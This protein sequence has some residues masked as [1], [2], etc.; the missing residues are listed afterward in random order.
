[1][2]AS[3]SEG[4]TTCIRETITLEERL[5]WYDPRDGEV[6]SFPA[7][8]TVFVGRG[9]VVNDTPRHGTVVRDLSALAAR[10]NA[11]Q[12]VEVKS[13]WEDLSGNAAL[14]YRAIRALVTVPEQTVALFDARL[15]PAAPRDAVKVQRWIAE[16]D[17]DDFTTREKATA[18]LANLG[19]PVETALRDA[20]A[21]SRAPEQRRRLQE[22]LTRLDE[23]SPRLSRLHPGQVR[24]LRAIEA[25]EEIATPAARE[26]LQRLA[27][28][29][30]SAL[31]TQ[32]ARA[33]LQRLGGQP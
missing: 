24:V 32:H 28:G 17:A 20:L 9:L 1:M 23:A 25:L 19:V 8:R 27:K 16:L 14:A 29:E 33:A 10:Q 11:G 13:L 31:E 26:I 6:W 2:L 7:S 30:P 4:W 5:K 12:H 3:V 21:S 15:R 18:E 22:L